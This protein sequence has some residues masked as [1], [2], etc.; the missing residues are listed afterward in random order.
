MR[1]VFVQLSAFH[2]LRMATQNVTTAPLVSVAPTISVS[3]PLSGPFVM[4]VS[5]ISNV[6]DALSG[7]DA[8]E[9]GLQYD[10]IAMSQAAQSS[11]MCS[12]AC[13]PSSPVDCMQWQGGLMSLGLAPSVEHYL[14]LARSLTDSIG[15]AASLN[16][17]LQQPSM[18][19]VREFERDYSPPVLQASLEAF[20]QAYRNCFSS[21]SARV[22]SLIGFMLAILFFYWFS[23]LPQMQ[24]LNAE[25]LRI[26]SIFLLVPSSV[27]E[28]MCRTSNLKTLLQTT[29]S[30]DDHF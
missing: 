6:L 13:V 18:R 9:H 26:C 23:Y 14:S 7:L 24:R 5:G 22:S 17:T 16:S 20:T 10:S 29:V 25:A 4:P 19:F 27:L 15:V 2:L 30:P 28:N 3:S 1:S 12:S 8:F 21:W 11:L